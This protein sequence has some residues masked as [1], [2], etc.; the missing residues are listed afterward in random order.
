MTIQQ[1]DNRHDNRN[2]DD[3]IYLFSTLTS[4]N[5]ANKN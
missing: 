5:F 4:F 3:M 2:N 1:Q